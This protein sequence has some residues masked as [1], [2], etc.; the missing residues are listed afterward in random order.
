MGAVPYRL[1]L[2]VVMEVVQEIL[3][4]ELTGVKLADLEKAFASL[5]HA[6]RSGEKKGKHLIG[7]E[8]ERLLYLTT[9]MP[10]TYAVVNSVLSTFKRI[11]GERKRYT[12]LDIGSGPGTFLLAAQNLLSIT[13]ATFIEKDAGWRVWGQK[14]FATP[15]AWHIADI[16]SEEYPPHDIVALSYSLGEI[17]DKKKVIEQCWEKTSQFLFIMEPGTPAG[18]ANIREARALLLNKGAHL[19]AP[20]THCAVCPI[21]GSDWCHFSVR[22]PRSS[23][24]RRIK[25]GDLGYEDEKFSYL[26]FSKSAVHLPLAR[27]VRRP[28]KNKGHVRLHLCQEGKIEEKVVSKKQGQLYREACDLEWGDSF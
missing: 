3:A 16:A 15:V 17:A 10:A 22:L 18:F 8:L 20:C 26:I 24:H 5:S 7:S 12:L 14:F 4:R 27:I 19:V 23:L 9:R 11:V 28:Q 6:Y 21:A 2:A 13:K 1:E 25:G